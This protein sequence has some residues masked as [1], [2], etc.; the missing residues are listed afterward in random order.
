[1]T[2]TPLI[3]VIEDDS[4][5]RRGLVDALRFAGY[6]TAECGDGGRAVDCA[7]ETAPNLI[8]LDVL[9]P[10]RSGFDILADLRRLQ[11]TLPVIMVT[12]KGAEQDRVRGLSD[13]ADDY[14]V[15]P[16]SPRELLARVEAV[17]RR[18]PERGGDVAEVAIDERRIDL[19]RRE[20]L[21]ASGERRSLSDREAAIIRYLAANRGRAVDRQELLHR[22]WGLNPKGITTRTVDMHIA[23]LREKVGDVEPDR[24][25]VQTVRSK[26][27]MLSN[28]ARVLEPARSATP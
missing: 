3:L 22:V 4:A 13:G 11:P 17:L 28:L 19:R 12:A 25:L 23:R 15:K 1:M 9:L 27:Y 18:S 24:Q 5:I 8:L 16:F 7:S 20:I 6:R 10:G 2:A 21:L 14:I 26:G